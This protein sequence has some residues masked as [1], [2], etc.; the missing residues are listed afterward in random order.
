MSQLR[1]SRPQPSP[2]GSAPGQGRPAA[3]YRIRGGVP[4]DPDEGVHPEMR[5]DGLAAGPR[6]GIP[7]SPSELF[8]LQE[9]A[10]LPWP[11][12]PEPALSARV[13]QV[14]ELI[15]RLDT[16]P[17]DDLALAL[18]L[19]SR[20]ESFHDGVVEEMR[21]DGGASHT[22]LISWAIDA[23]RLM[24]ARILLENVDAV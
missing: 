16:R 17:A 3:R 1:N 13:Q 15:E 7:A 18:W 2:D 21:H 20:L 4:V 14:L 5:A 24:Q 12:T 10:G 22:Q 19:V 23:D 11:E 8:A 9:N 6:Q